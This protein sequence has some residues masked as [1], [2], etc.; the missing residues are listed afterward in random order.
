MVL[1]YTVI[2]LRVG[3]QSSLLSSPR[4]P[5]KG[6]GR[7]LSSRTRWFRTKKPHPVCWTLLLSTAF[8]SIDLVFR[9]QVS[10]NP[11]QYS[12]HMVALTRKI[13]II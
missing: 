11:H 9:H 10:I 1:V 3:T 7:N 5:G 12:I 2:E 13:L 4:A 8:R 6:L